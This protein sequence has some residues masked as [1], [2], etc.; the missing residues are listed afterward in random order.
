MSSNPLFD[1]GGK[2]AAYKGMSWTEFLDLVILG[3]LDEEEAERIYYLQYHRPPQ[4]TAPAPQKQTQQKRAGCDCDE[5]DNK[6]L[7]YRRIRD[8]KR[9]T[10]RKAGYAAP[11]HYRFRI[12]PDD[13][14]PYW[15]HRRYGWVPVYGLPERQLLAYGLS[16]TLARAVLMAQGF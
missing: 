2:Y 16:R 14:R 12:N 15:R 6:I 11:R 4:P 10:E 9:R 13:G 8:E 1:K 3:E 5:L 7:E